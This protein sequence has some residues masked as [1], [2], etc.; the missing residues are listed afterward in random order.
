M[1]ARPRVAVTRDLPRRRGSNRGTALTARVAIFWCRISLSVPAAITSSVVVIRII[2]PA[3]I[4]IICFILASERH[5]KINPKRDNRVPSRMLM[6]AIH[7][8][9][10]AS[11]LPKQQQ[12]R[13]QTQL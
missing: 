6:A 2:G 1:R 3:I 4:A 12:V 8:T 7:H 9:V 13:L 10:S 5:R 11:K